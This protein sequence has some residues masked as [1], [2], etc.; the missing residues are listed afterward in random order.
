MP[1]WANGI[2]SGVILLQP[3]KK[4]NHTHTHT[5]CLKSPVNLYCCKINR[6]TATLVGSAQRINPPHD[7]H[8]PHFMGSVLQGWRTPSFG[9]FSWGIM[10]S[11]GKGICITQKWRLCNGCKFFK[12]NQYLLSCGTLSDTYQIPKSDTH[13]YQI[14]NWLFKLITFIKNPGPLK[15]N[16]FFSSEIMSRFT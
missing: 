4:K 7:T 9:N 2:K 8:S 12:W 10:G 11:G 5:Q 1:C 13:Y 14:L 15:L 16:A 6:P 3:T